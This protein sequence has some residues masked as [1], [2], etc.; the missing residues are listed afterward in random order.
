MPTSGHSAH[1]S[2]RAAGSLSRENR[3]SLSFGNGRGAHERPYY[4]DGTVDYVIGVDVS[5]RRIAI[6]NHEGDET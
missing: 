6:F 1:F 3:R 5:S 4:Y 2:R